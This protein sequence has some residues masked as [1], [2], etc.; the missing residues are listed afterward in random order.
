[1]ELRPAQVDVGA[2]MPHSLLPNPDFPAGPR[3]PSSQGRGL[4]RPPAQS[5]R[6]RKPYPTLTE[7]LLRVVLSVHTAA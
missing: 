6:R 3:P 1:M 4:R 7:D 2:F 5:P